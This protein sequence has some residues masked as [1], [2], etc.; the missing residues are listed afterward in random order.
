MTFLI[1]PLKIRA[2]YATSKLNKSYLSYD[3]IKDLRLTPFD[4]LI[5]KLFLG[6]NI[7]P[8]DIL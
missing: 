3:R 7:V 4:A 1:L 6:F 8:Q 2:A 5:K